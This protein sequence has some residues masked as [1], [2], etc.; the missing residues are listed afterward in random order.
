MNPWIEDAVYLD[1]LL[2]TSNVNASLHCCFNEKPRRCRL[3]DDI[4]SFR[5]GLRVKRVYFLSVV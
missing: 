1:Q 4:L 5:L 2:E 3:R